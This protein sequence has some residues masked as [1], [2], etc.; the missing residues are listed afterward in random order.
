M[1][2]EKACRPNLLTS[3]LFL[4]S[5]CLSCLVSAQPVTPKAK[6]G[7]IDLH[8][9]DLTQQTVPL[10]GEWKFYWNHLL[11][12]GESSEDYEYVDFPRL[13][14][15]TQ[16][17]Q[18]ALPSSGYATYSLD[19]VLP[20]DSSGMLALNLPDV[21]TAYRLYGNNQILAENGKPGKNAKTSI[22]Y[23][24]PRVV[25]IPS[26]TDT[27][28]LLFQISNYQHAK[29]GPYKDITIGPMTSLLYTQQAES[30]FNTFLAGCLFMG[31]L[32]FIGLFL[33]GRHDQTILYFSLFSLLYSYRIIG[34]KQYALHTLLP[35]IPWT[36]TLHC[37]YLALYLSIGMFV[38]YTQKLYPKDSHK[39][40]MNV[41]F[42]V[43]MSFAFLTLVLP[44][45]LFT[46]LVTPFLVVM[47]LGIPYTVYVYY[48]ATLHNR[49]GARYALMSTVALML[50]F[51]SILLEYFGIASPSKLFL[52]IGYLGFFFLQSLILSFRFT[53]ALKTARDHAERALRAKSEFLS[54]MSHE[55]RTPLNSVIGMTH[56]LLKDT[57]RL[58]QKQHLD[59]LLF[60]AKN[61]LSIVND[62]LDY[63]KI[64]AGMI[65][66]VPAPMD[67]LL[68]CRNIASGYT[69]SAIDQGIMLR[70]QLDTSLKNQVIADQTRMSQVISNL[71]HNAVKFTP[72]GSVTLRLVVEEQT[73]KEVTITISIE[74]TGI[75]IAPE[76]H[77]EIFDRF[78]QVDSSA[79]RGFGGTGLGLAIT[80][81]I[82]EL[83]KADLQ[84]S[85]EPGVG[86][87]FSFTLT[88][89]LAPAI[90]APVKKALVSDTR[91]AMPL[92][93]IR[94]L[95]VDDN[96]MNI[97][98]VQNFLKR[99]GAQSEV[100]SN[101]QEAIDKLDN[102]HD[103]I[104]MDLHMPVM[105]G[106]EATRRLREQGKSLPIIALTAS[107][108]QEV[109][110][111]V[112]EYG[113]DDLVVKPFNPDEL[114][115][116]IL[117]YVKHKV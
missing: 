37:E 105:D 51:L 102:G 70:T 46:S 115:D 90:E 18:K 112:Y 88:F 35:G 47:V 74:D 103:L 64:E 2:C 109:K 55:I 101:G 13:W 108:A 39:T 95:V 93:D 53:S 104:L 92:Q 32:L 8:T 24:S 14:S 113:F 73:E 4:I 114:L 3:F 106:Y 7:M 25:P 54:T 31:G 6:Q 72:K 26:D 80:K 76:K 107:L 71:V 65:T 34:T 111:K 56:L 52:F 84:L 11:Q 27:L 22:P 77:K 87:T 75:G 86:S 58:D 44:T 59:V 66:F 61:L 91:A 100:A 98:V 15:Q 20:Q 69:Q 63:N 97:L 50:I 38:L 33:F 85:S 62:I 48:R 99:W 21:Y 29:G 30:G 12:P 82:L 23:W 96:K 83:Q 45:S 28:R 67:L 5:L 110:D 68:V 9:I 60:S 49:T 81:R 43:C 42:G 117:T 116:T 16:W 1:I 94:L 78:T 36:F 89:P 79:T 17:K 40:V 41:F 10:H 19:V 57:P